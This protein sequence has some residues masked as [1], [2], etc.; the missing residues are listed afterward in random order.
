MLI[1]EG[2]VIDSL[3]KAKSLIVFVKGREGKLFFKIHNQYTNIDLKA[4]LTVSD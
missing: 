1:G 3:T 2:D 4:N